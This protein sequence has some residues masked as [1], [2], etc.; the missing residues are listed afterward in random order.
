MRPIRFPLPM[1][2]CAAVPLHAQDADYI[3]AHYTKY[4]YRIAVRD[5][6]RLFAI[7]YVSQRHDPELPDHPHPDT[8]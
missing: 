8:V 6:V 5:G 1:L 4:E 7:V 3:R 2:V